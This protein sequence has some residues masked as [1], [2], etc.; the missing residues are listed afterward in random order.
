MIFKLW[1]V[2]YDACD[3]SNGIVRYGFHEVFKLVL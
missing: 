2:Q 1:V 3:I